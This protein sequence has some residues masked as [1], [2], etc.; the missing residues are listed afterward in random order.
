MLGER[1]GGVRAAHVHELRLLSPL[2]NRQIDLAAALFAQ[3]ARDLV[4]ALPLCVD[5]NILR[6]VGTEG[7]VAE[8]ELLGI[9]LA[10]VDDKALAVK[11][12]AALKAEHLEAGFCTV[13]ECRDNILV[14]H[15]VC[16]YLLLVAHL[17]YSGDFVAYSRGALKLQV[18]GSLLHLRGELL[19]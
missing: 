12:P 5:G 8:D 7:V 4:H 10:A 13:G 19:Y 11:Q 17:L 6:N 1:L 18:L 3:P 15:L 9:A 16:D 2:R 14:E